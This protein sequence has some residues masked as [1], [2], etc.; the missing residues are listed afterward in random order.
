MKASTIVQTEKVGPAGGT[1]GEVKDMDISGVTR[2]V[3]ISIRH[4]PNIDAFSVTFL[5]NGLEEK[6][7]QWGGNAGILE[8]VPPF[9]ISILIYFH[10]IWEWKVEVSISM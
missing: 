2:I 1:E 4:S 8:E 5:R 6:T 7:E 10:L 9:C 3:K